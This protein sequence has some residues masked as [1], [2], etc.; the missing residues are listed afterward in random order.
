MKKGILVICLMVLI[1]STAVVMAAQGDS[2]RVWIEGG[3]VMF[4]HCAEADLDH[5]EFGNYFY[6]IILTTTVGEPY[7]TEYTGSIGRDVGDANAK[8][9]TVLF[10]PP[11]HDSKTGDV[12]TSYDIDSD[13]SEDFE[14]DDTFMADVYVYSSS[15]N[16]F[17]DDDNEI[18]RLTLKNQLMILLAETE[19]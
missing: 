19:E 4:L 14:Y 5:P 1:A 17:S 2:S 12:Y 11:G 15:D 7:A 16:V 9:F 8:L 6:R 13:N 3:K 18:I 10:T